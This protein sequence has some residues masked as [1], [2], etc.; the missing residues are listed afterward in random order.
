MC[1]EGKGEDTLGILTI[2]RD[3]DSR[4]KY[5]PIDTQDLRD[6]PLMI[7]KHKE[8]LEVLEHEEEY[9]IHSVHYENLLKAQIIDV[10]KGVE[11]T[12]LG[13]TIDEV[14][15]DAK[16]SKRATRLL[17]DIHRE[18]IKYFKTDLMAIKKKILTL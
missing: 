4:I 2:T 8:H 6:D 14:Q 7:I 13:S 12:Y 16:E 9:D 5:P 11:H 18:K 15:V 10:V 1:E 3:D 17:D